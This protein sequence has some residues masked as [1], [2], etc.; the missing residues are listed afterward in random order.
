MCSSFLLLALGTRDL[1]QAE[2]KMNT[3]KAEQMHK[4][5]KITQNN[6]QGP[7]CVTT[8]VILC[9]Y[10]QHSKQLHI[11]QLAVNHVTQE[12]SANN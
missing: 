11:S 8:I 3:C 2:K 12:P 9:T 7:L 10:S 5:T 4:M 1:S 6:N